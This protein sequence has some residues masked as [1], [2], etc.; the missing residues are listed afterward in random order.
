MVSTKVRIGDPIPPVVSTSKLD[1]GTNSASVLY[2]QFLSDF[3]PDYDRAHP[4]EVTATIDFTEA[5]EGE[6]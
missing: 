1:Q 4:D 5:G 3:E 6:Y 2:T